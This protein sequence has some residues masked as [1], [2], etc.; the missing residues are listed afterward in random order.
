MHYENI[1]L[2]KCR[3]VYKFRIVETQFYYVIID[4]RQTT[5]TF[6][7]EK[8]FRMQ[9]TPQKD[10][11]EVVRRTIIASCPFYNTIMT[12]CIKLINQ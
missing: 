3:K 4:I 9:N 7:N 6:C 11:V 10:E 1:F 12:F 2:T 5:S 8:Y